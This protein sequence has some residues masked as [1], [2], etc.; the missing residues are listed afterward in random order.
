MENATI[1]ANSNV[2]HRAPLTL[3]F[4]IPIPIP[5][6]APAPTQPV[7]VTNLP[8]SFGATFGIVPHEAAIEQA[9]EDHSVVRAKL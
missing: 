3:P 4:P 1:T 6:P 9:M 8:G 2:P 5:A 7:D